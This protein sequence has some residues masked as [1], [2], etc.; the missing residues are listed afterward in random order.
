MTMSN[1]IGGIMG[2]TGGVGRSEYTQTEEEAM[3][4]EQLIQELADCL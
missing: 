4:K 3:P 1:G 2:T